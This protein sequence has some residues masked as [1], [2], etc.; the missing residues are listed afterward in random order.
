MA[1]INYASAPLWSCILYQ[2]CARRLCFLT[3]MGHKAAEKM[4]LA[5]S[6]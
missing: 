1:F 5:I 4:A 6:R 2:K 3:S